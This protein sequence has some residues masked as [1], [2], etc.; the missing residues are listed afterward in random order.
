MAASSSIVPLVLP[1]YNQMEG[2]KLEGPGSYLQWLSIFMPI[3]CNNELVGMIDGTEECPP[4]T[5]TNEK[6]ESTPNPKYSIW[7]KKDQHSL[8]R[9]NASL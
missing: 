1:N 2:V 8:S 7:I 3:L 4:K 9:I 5:L 6:G